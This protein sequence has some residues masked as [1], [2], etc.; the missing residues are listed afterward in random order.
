MTKQKFPSSVPENTATKLNEAIGIALSLAGSQKT[1]PTPNK[2]MK[3]IQYTL[4][5][6]S[7]KYGEKEFLRLARSLLKAPLIAHD[8][9]LKNSA[10][11]MILKIATHRYQD[12][13]RKTP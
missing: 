1:L 10:T 9:P 6:L 11:E 3:V 5:L 7:I 8:M 13:A 4:Q 2:T 12:G